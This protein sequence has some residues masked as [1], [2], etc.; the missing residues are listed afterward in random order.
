MRA[1]RLSL[2]SGEQIS[3]VAESFDGLSDTS[4]ESETAL[5]RIALE[6]HN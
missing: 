5:Q 4:L 6:A 2:V 3:V 1:L